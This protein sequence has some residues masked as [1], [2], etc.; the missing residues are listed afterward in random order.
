[1]LNINGPAELPLPDDDGEPL[2]SLGEL[3]ELA[4][5]AGLARQR[6]TK[7]SPPALREAFLRDM[8]DHECWPLGTYFERL[9]EAGVELP[10][11][12]LMD[13]AGLHAKLWEV[14]HALAAMNTYLNHTDHL[15]DRELYEHFWQDSLREV[16]E[17]PPPNSGWRRFIDLLGGCSEDD[18][19]IGLRYYHDEETRQQWA[20]D[21]PED[22]I[23]EHEE[24]P[25]DRDRLLPVPDEERPT[26]DDVE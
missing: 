6:V 1:M 13:D 25:F 14:I 19:Q 4:E 21:F 23:P 20:R 10:D 7:D 22:H 8:L 3:Q 24:P 17:M 15:S 5:A 11:P 2:G 26:P 9:G 12:A 16:D 18:I